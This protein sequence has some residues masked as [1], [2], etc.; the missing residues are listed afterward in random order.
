MTVKEK[1]STYQLLF[2]ALRNYKISTEV[3]ADI[4]HIFD[5]NICGLQMVDDN[6]Y[7]LLYKSGTKNRF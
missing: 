4:I 1:A 3:L 2:K 7:K 6:N 5:E